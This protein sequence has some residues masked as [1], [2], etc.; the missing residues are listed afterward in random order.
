[1]AFCFATMCVFDFVLEGVIWLPLGVFEYPGG[2]WA[3]FAMNSYHKYP[4]QEMVT[5]CGAFTAVAC[6]RFFINDRGQTMVE[7]GLDEVRAPAGRKVA[8]RLFATIAFMNL[9]MF[10]CY[11]LPNTI[12]S[13][14]QPSWPKDLQQRSYLTDYV[15]GAGTGGRLCPGPDVPVARNTSA[16]ES[17]GGK[18]VLPKGTKVPGIVPFKIH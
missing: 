1:V 12:M 14:N 8:A 7:R 10:C 2:H 16:Y 4:L 17:P 5:V 11:T 15:C 9:A 18:L 6:L 3:L 13:I